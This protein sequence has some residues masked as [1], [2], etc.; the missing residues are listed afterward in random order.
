MSG[1]VLCKH[2]WW[3]MKL[4][5]T[6]PTVVTLR[7]GGSGCDY[8]ARGRIPRL[9]VSWV[10]SA[11]NSVQQTR[12]WEAS[13]EILRILWNPKAVSHIHKS[14][15]P[16]S[17]LSHVDTV[18]AP[19]PTPRRSI[20]IL[21]TLPLYSHICLGL[22]SGNLPSGFP[23]KILHAPL[24]SVYLLHALRSTSAPYSRKPSAYFPPSMWA[25]RFHTNINKRQNY[26]S[27]Y[28]N[29]YVFG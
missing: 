28:L 20:L 23:I 14:P 7:S 18:H 2:V 16:V 9:R 24:L 6:H 17:V 13:Q 22:P 8:Q 19:H 26:S 4:D 10:S 12:S 1:R 15:P 5:E 25:T 11:P 29:L 3:G 21:S 27:V